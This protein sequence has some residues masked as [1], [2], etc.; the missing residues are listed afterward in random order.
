MPEVLSVFASILHLNH[1]SPPSSNLPFSYVFLLL[2]S[3]SVFLV[4][5][6]VL[7][8]SKQLRSHVYQGLN[9]YQK[10]NQFPRSYEITTKDN[11]CRN[12]TR[13]K[14]IHGARHFDFSPAGFVLPG[15]LDLFFKVVFSFFVFLFFFC[16]QSQ[17]LFLSL[18]HT[19]LISYFP[20]SFSLSLFL[21]LSCTLS[22]SPLSLSLSL[23]L[24]PIKPKK[25]NGNGTV[26]SPGS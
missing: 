5:R 25:R 24:S 17:C 16:F 20:Y 21:S 8:S 18:S 19:T 2:C 1:L 7:W 9:P 15:E 10:V 6:N 14:Q 13:M 12:I 4:I 23:F 26:V 11:L 3:F 22:R